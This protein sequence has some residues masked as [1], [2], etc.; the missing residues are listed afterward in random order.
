[1]QSHEAPRSG[2]IEPQPTMERRGFLKAVGSAVGLAALLGPDALRGVEA[3]MGT[4]AGLT[5]QQ[6]AREESLWSSVQQAF[7]MNRG[8]IHLDNGFTCPTPRVVSEAVA[9]YIEDQEEVPYGLWLQDARNRMSTVRTGLARLFGC[10]PDEIAITRNATEAL[11]TILYGF[12][13]KPGD[14]VLTTTQDYDSM[15]AT[16][17]HRQQR[18]G[19]TLTKVDVP[20]PPK[21]M[22]DLVGIFERG[23]TPKTRLILVSH[24]TYTTG[25][26]FPVKRICDLAH[27]RG[28]DVL[29][30]GAHSFGHLDFKLADLNCDYFGTSLHKWLLAPKGTGMLYIQKDKIEKIPPIM[31]PPPRRGND[32]M[33][34]YESV[35]IQSSAQNLGIG[36][37]LAFHNAIGAKRKEERLRY[38][39]HAWAERLQAVPTIRLYTPL[40][41]EMSCGIA[42][43]GIVG[44]DP[45]ALHNFLWEKHRIQTSRGYYEEDR[46]LLWLRIS[47]NLYTTLPELEY[48]Y[49]GME[50]AAKN[51]LPEPY[52]SY[53]PDLSRFNG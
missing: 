48:F 1:M 44:V 22:D 21:S 18:D 29:V 17:E 12:A 34:K 43:V 23:I 24:I 49:E 50:D 9:R 14:E 10:D 11:R 16:L 32:R 39:T 33:R 15:L 8:L 20:T 27:S 52:R 45:T 30:D 47:P 28:V 6:A 4:A 25:Q 46:T 51:G 40:A 36:E 3:A 31:S 13:L 5:P 26:V 19:I 53:K 35:G 38:L 42:S 37:A 7:T 2:G 41:P